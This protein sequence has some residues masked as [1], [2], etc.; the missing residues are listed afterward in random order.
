MGEGSHGGGDAILLSDVFRGPGAD[1]LGR[2]AGY[3]DGIRAVAVGIAG[4]ESM[5]TGQPVDISA[6]DLGARVPAAR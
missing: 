4:N 6:L 1:A 2:P 3:T 5:R